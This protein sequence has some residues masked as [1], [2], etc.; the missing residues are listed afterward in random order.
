[1]Y[2]PTLDICLVVCMVLKI[3][4]QTERLRSW[5]RCQDAVP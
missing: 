5:S 2:I 3:M 4:L 1:M